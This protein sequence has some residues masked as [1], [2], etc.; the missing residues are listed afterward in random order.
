MW[1][2]YVNGIGTEASYANLQGRGPAAIFTDGK[3]IHG[4]WSRGP[5]KGDV[6]QYT[7]VAGQTLQLTPGQTWVEL[8]NSGAVLSVTP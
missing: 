4:I 3:V 2:T 8:L 6:I 5:A 7:T 1:V